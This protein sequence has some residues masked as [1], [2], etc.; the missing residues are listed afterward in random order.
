[1]I[2]SELFCDQ[3]DTPFVAFEL[4]CRLAQWF[5]VLLVMSNNTIRMIFCIGMV[6][7]EDLGYGKKLKIALDGNDIDNMFRIFVVIWL[8]F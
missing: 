8:I 4:V 3:V 7:C 6:E 5:C 1:M 2:T